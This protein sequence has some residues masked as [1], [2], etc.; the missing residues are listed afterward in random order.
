MTDRVKNIAVLGSTGSIGRSTR[1]V[2]AA[3]QD[4]VLRCSPRIAA[5]NCS[6]SKP[7]PAPAA[8]DRRHRPRGG[9]RPLDWST[10]RRGSRCYS[11]G[12]RCWPA[13]ADRSIDIVVPRLSSAARGCVDL[14]AA[15][16]AGKTVALAN[17]ESLVVGG[18]LVTGLAQRAAGRA[19]A[20]STA[21]IA[22]CSRPLQAGRREEVC[23]VVLT[24]SGGPFRGHSA[25]SSWPR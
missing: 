7:G 5:P 12:D 22:P 16:E 19:A 21:S 20:H 9:G 4:D 24:A 18:P 2:I 14:A 11:P 3:S 17:K 8:A 23:R 10:C 1:E 6:K 25:G 13:V 15:P